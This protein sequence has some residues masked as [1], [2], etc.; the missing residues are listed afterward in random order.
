[1]QPS[2]GLLCNA[3][4]YRT[5]WPALG[6]PHRVVMEIDVVNR[7]RPLARIDRGLGGEVEAIEVADAG[8]MNDLHRHLDAPLVQ[9]CRRGPTRG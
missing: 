5:H 3:F 7:V 8:E 6:R 9:Q 4:A 2:K 1:M